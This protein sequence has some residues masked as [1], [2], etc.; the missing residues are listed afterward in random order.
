LARQHPRAAE[1]D[2]A[3]RDRLRDGYAHHRR[4]LVPRESRA[5]QQPGHSLADDL[6]AREREAI[7]Q[8]LA[9]SRGRVAGPSGAAAKLGIRGSTLESKIKAFGIRKERFK[10]S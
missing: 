10:D 7:E 8:A 2:R 4:Q 3:L 1:R 9:A 5:P 6:A